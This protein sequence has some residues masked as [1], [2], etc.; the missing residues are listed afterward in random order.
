M[1][2]APGPIDRITVRLQKACGEKTPDISL[3][4]L[5]VWSLRVGMMVQRG[6]DQG[7]SHSEAGV[8]G[9]SSAQSPSTGQGRCVIKQAGAAMRGGG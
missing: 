6:G 3:C 7:I 1:S 5:N 2:S 9:Q 8:R 4:T